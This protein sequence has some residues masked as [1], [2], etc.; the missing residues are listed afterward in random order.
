VISDNLRWNRFTFRPGDIV[1]CT[2]PKCGTTWMQMIVASL[3]FP[4]GL[5]GPLF[6]ICPWLDAR[7]E[8]VDL[9]IDRLEAQRH[10]RAI[11]THTAADGVPWYPEAAYI[12]VGRDGRDSAMSMLNHA[13]TMRVPAELVTSAI[14]DGIDLSRAERP[15][16]DDVHAYFDW[17]MERPVWFEHVAS[18][19]PHRGEPNVLFAHFNDLLSDLDGQMRRVSNFLEIPVDED[20]WPEQVARCRFERMRERSADISD[21]ARFE[22]GAKAFLYKGTNGRWRDVFTADE[23]ARYEQRLEEFLSADAIAWTIFGESAI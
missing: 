2:P 12:V 5:P 23:L 16:V 4:E 19:W 6:E 10:R 7:F 18:F 11:K 20:R 13:R 17:F 15:P 14:D 8:P 9:V 1:V 3:I 21:F 22:G